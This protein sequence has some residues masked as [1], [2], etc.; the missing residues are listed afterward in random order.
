MI[1]R[2]QR[3][4]QDERGQAVSVMVLGFVAAL[5][6]VAGLVIDGGQKAAAISR[7]ETLAAGA[8]RAAANA[9]AGATLGSGQDARLAS[10]QARRAAT[11]YLAAASTTGDR[12][13]GTVSVRDT[14]VNVRT[15]VTVNTIFLSLIGITTLRASGD[16]TA[17][18]VPA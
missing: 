14:T 1:G 10:A 3:P 11:T 15:D 13:R 7:A 12:V 2:I 16:A 4:R 6:M 17:R 18:M 9:G 8:A 5:I